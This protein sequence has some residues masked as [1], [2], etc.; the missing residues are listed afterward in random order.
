[1]ND[2]ASKYD[3]M[4]LRENSFY[5]QIG[6]AELCITAIINYIFQYGDL[7]DKLTIEEVLNVIHQIEMD[8][9]TNL[10]HLRLEKAFVACELKKVQYD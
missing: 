8:L 10:L 2:L 3:E 1:M 7:T 9:R 6:T 4:A 5:K